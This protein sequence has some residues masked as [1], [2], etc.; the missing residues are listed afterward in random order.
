MCECVCVYIYIYMIYSDDLQAVIQLIQY[1]YLRTEGPR[2]QVFQSTRL[3]FK[4]ISKCSQV[5]N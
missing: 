4:N 1:G 5:Y 3:I 2:I